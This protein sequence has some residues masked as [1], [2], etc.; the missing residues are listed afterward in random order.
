MFKDAFHVNHVNYEVQSAYKDYSGRGID[1][2]PRVK[3]IFVILYNGG[4]LKI[5]YREMDYEK[6]RNEH[7]KLFK[8]T[9]TL[10]H[11]TK[12]FRKLPKD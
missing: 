5:N 7:T 8:L 10:K 6:I 12:L 9:T 2:T 3:A 4:N 1:V 11:P